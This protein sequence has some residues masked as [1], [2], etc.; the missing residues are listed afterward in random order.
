MKKNYDLLPSEEN[1]ESHD[2]KMEQMVLGTILISNKSYSIVSQLI[3][4]EKVFYAKEHQMIY[5]SIQEC[6]KEMGKADILIVSQHLRKNKK[7]ALIGGAFYLTTCTGP[8]ASDANINE[9]CILL[10]S[11]YMLRTTEEF[12]MRMANSVYDQYGIF[13]VHDMINDLRS[14]ADYIDKLIKSSNYISLDKVGEQEVKEI[15]ED[16]AIKS[17]PGLSSGFPTL[18]RLT[19]RLLPGD[20]WVIAARPGMGKT[21]LAFQMAVNIAEFYPNHNIDFWSLEVKAFR[22]AHRYITLKTGIS[23]KKIL[24]RELTAY[25]LAKIDETYMPNNIR[26]F[27]S[28]SA[29]VKG[30]DGYYKSES[31]EQRPKILMFDYL[32]LAIPDS[33]GNGQRNREQDVAEI[34]RG[35]KRLATELSIPVIALSQLNREIEKRQDKKPKLSDLRESGAI[36]QDADL[37][38]FIYRSNYYDNDEDVRNS[39]GKVEIL[40]EKNRHGSVGSAVMEFIPKEMK[41]QEHNSINP[42]TGQDYNEDINDTTK[43]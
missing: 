7:L 15:H 32:Q 2:L 3:S 43:F 41:F 26:I 4:T 31:K 8:V 1:S 12:T 29:S 16:M 37:V 22:I 13:K 35:L 30:M 40:I 33:K 36:E 21:S 5:T 6:M 23:N 38:G 42:N 25:E 17:K 19:G 10:V 39:T 9:H 24:Y 20:L 34:S 18:D 11:M 14:H 27:D 28:T